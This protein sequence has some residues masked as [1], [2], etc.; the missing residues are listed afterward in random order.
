ML[1]QQWSRR[2]RKCTLS[3]L[4]PPHWFAFYK[5]DPHD[6]EEEEDVES[7]HEKEDEDGEG[8]FR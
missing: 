1:L 3:L 6:D 2:K 8:D 5:I 7:D 4:R